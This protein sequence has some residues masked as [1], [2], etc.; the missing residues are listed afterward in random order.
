MSS[1]GTHNSYYSPV[2]DMRHMNNMNNMNNMQNGQ[3][4]Q[5]AGWSNGADGVEGQ[6]PGGDGYRDGQQYAVQ[7]ANGYQT[8]GNQY[9]EEGPQGGYPGYGNPY[10]GDGNEGSYGHG[11]QYGEQYGNRYNSAAENPYH[12]PSQ[13]NNA[14]HS[15][16]SYSYGGP[17][18]LNEVHVS[19][20]EDGK[21]YESDQGHGG[22][23]DKK[24]SK[25]KGKGKKAKKMK[26]RPQPPVSNSADGASNYFFLPTVI[27]NGVSTLSSAW[28][29][30]EEVAGDSVGSITSLI[31]FG[32][33]DAKAEEATRNDLLSKWLG[34]EASKSLSFMA[35]SPRVFKHIRILFV[36]LLNVLKLVTVNLM[37]E[38]VAKFHSRLKEF[39]VLLGHPEHSV[40]SML[41]Q[42]EE[43]EQ[44]GSKLKDFAHIFRNIEDHLSRSIMYFTRF[45]KPNSF[46]HF[47]VGT[48]IRDFFYNIDVRLAA[49][50]A[51]LV[52][53]VSVSVGV[54]ISIFRTW[55]TELE[56]GET[57]PYMPHCDL[58]RYR[59]HPELNSLEYTDEIPLT[60]GIYG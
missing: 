17:E 59:E 58:I 13:S 2:G 21:Q 8:Y 28:E 1:H 4:A 42:L 11:N 25:A 6:Y 19:Q 57:P 35:E 29:S 60:E 37:K 30:V 45:T 55:T 49:D 48:E 20:D 15:G 31:S 44:L 16:E 27:Q 36:Q 24:R 52:E 51:V 40:M 23:G 41:R 46:V 54:G 38:S 9:G 22:A 5:G 43:A 12:E 26:G 33:F 14:S 47:L 34:A 3:N 53:T 32:L 39:V 56:L 18:N 10:G 7:G 50:I